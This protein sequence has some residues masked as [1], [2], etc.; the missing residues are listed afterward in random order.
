[1]DK[2]VASTPGTQ[3]LYIDP[4]RDRVRLPAADLS[5]MAVDAV[6]LFRSGEPMK[7][8]CVKR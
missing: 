8:G 4:K 6:L 5:K 7:T 1:L 2:V 3:F